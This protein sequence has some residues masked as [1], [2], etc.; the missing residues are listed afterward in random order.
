MVKAASTNVVDRPSFYS[1]CIRQKSIYTTCDSSTEESE[2]SSSSDDSLGCPPTLSLPADK[3]ADNIPRGTNALPDD[4]SHTAIVRARSGGLFT[5]SVAM[6]LSICLVWN[7]AW[8]ALEFSQSQPSDSATIVTSVPR[9]T[10][11]CPSETNHLT[12][13]P[14]WKSVLEMEIL[15]LTNL[16]HAALLGATSLLVYLRGDVLW[17]YFLRFTTFFWTVI[18]VLYCLAFVY[19]TTTRTTTTTVNMIQGAAMVVFTVLSGLLLAQYSRACSAIRRYCRRDLELEGQGKTPTTSS[20]F[21]WSHAASQ[22]ILHCGCVVVQIASLAYFVMTTFYW[23]LLQHTM[24][25]ND[26][27]FSNDADNERRV[28]RMLHDVMT[29]PDDSILGMNNTNAAVTDGIETR[30]TTSMEPFVMAY[31]EMAHTA[32]ILALIQL[33]ATYPGDIATLTA[34]ILAVSW[35]LLISTASFLHILFW[36]SATTLPSATSTTW[37]GSSQRDISSTIFTVV[38]VVSMTF[39]LASSVWLFLLCRRVNGKPT[40]SSCFEGD[41]NL[42]GCHPSNEEVGAT[43]RHNEDRCASRDNANADHAELGH[44]ST[45]L[46]NDG[47]VKLEIGEVATFCCTTLT[48]ISNSGRFSARQQCGALLLSIGSTM[49][50]TEMTM[51]CLLLLSQFMVGSDETHDLYKWGMHSCIMYTFC[52]YMCVES[53]Y[54]YQRARSLLG[55]A[56][57]LGTIVACWQLWFFLSP[58]SPNTKLDAWSIV[59]MLLLTT[60]A[61]SGLVQ[62]AGL[63]F[64]NNTEPCIVATVPTTR[65]VTAAEVDLLSNARSRSANSL[66]LVFIPTLLAY[67]ATTALSG[68]C[69]APMISLMLPLDDMV[70]KSCEMLD[71]MGSMDLML[72]QN[73]PGLGVFFHFG[74]VVVFFA[75]DGIKYTPPSYKPSLVIAMLV[76]GQL[77]IFSFASLLWDTLQ[78]QLWSSL[79]IDDVV[80]RVVLL[81]W[82]LAAGYMSF[83]LRQLWKLRLQTYE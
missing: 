72:M 35:R 46:E 57:P 81:A 36:R 60:R 69:F 48:Q 58:V 44:A 15:M 19:T 33:A 82:S 37:F 26:C 49:L 45:A 61:A 25:H 4:E 12:D 80:R 40:Y 34:C 52:T 62:I 59:T 16:I 17:L 24:N 65:E 2:S 64:L 79:S 63:F 10:G 77:F 53:T 47:L 76:A 78:T 41:I 9:Y 28:L 42:G 21:L 31:S 75:F 43:Y 68:N 5:L 74:L 14:S 70:L 11:H 71:S 7:S 50:L 66:Y 22:Q 51:E 54:V 56:C 13:S 20:R 23:L 55:F 8:M 39:M 83:C 1:T 67:V 18:G 29:M 73:T 38:E 30:Q 32:F 27:E 6:A 3:E